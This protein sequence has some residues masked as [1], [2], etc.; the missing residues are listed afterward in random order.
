MRTL[1][2][3]FLIAFA[4]VLGY[5]VYLN[6]KA[7]TVDLFGQEKDTTIPILAGAVYLLGMFTGWAVVGV[8]RR[9]LREVTETDRR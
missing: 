9:S 6:Q 7:V 3:I 8:L 1:N 5:F 4:A 2:L